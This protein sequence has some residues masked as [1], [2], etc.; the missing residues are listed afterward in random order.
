[1]MIM[2]WRDAKWPPRTSDPK[3]KDPFISQVKVSAHQFACGLCNLRWLSRT[4]WVPAK[5]GPPEHSG[6]IQECRL[7]KMLFL[8]NAISFGILSVDI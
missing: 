6:G 4:V 7:L 8:K 1:M 3:I 5:P 2:F